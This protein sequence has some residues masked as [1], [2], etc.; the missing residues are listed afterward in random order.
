LESE[1]RR[2]FKDS[3]LADG[4]ANGNFSAM[5]TS[6]DGA[7]GLMIP[8]DIRHESEIKPGIPLEVRLSNGINRSTFSGVL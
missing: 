3:D 4:P 5:K 8:K 6:F 2:E 7:G 1:I